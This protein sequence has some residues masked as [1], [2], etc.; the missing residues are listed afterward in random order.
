MA[1]KHSIA[2]ARRHLPRLVRE[3]EHGKTVELTRRGAPVAVLVGHRTF[4]RLS[5]G[6][7]AFVEAYREF[8]EAVDLSELAIDPDEVFEGARD[9]TP[10]RD[11]RV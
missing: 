8:V 7:R 11:V 2:E 9:A 4:E 3:A 1:E 6:R 10:G 5:A